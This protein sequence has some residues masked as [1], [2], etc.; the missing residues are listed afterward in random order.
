MFSLSK[1]ISTKTIIALLT[2]NKG[3]IFEI[4]M[5]TSCF[6]ATHIVYFGG[7]K[8]FDMGIDSQSVAWN[9]KEFL[10]FYLPAYWTVEQVI[11]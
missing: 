9:P 5:S 1:K 11:S 2:I 6:K 4:S 8:I 7:R 10:S 3:T